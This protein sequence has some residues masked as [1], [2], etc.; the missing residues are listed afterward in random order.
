MTKIKSETELDFFLN[1]FPSMSSANSNLN[2]C[3][4]CPENDLHKMRA[5]YPFCRCSPNCLTRYLILKCLKSPTIIVK[6]LNIHPP[7]S[8]NASYQPEMKKKGITA[9]FKEIIEDL[10][11]RN[12]SKPFKV[13]QQILLNHL[14]LTTNQGQ[15]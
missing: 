2:N 8:N 5:V 7:S 1:Q 4:I 12:I 14:N 15:I 13:Y 6:G 11:F 10:M 9:K 3:T